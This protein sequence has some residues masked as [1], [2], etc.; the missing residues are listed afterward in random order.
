MERSLRHN[1]YVHD[2]EHPER[3]LVLSPRGSRD[4]HAAFLR[5]A[6]G[7]ADT[8]GKNQLWLYIPSVSSGRVHFEWLRFRAVLKKNIADRLSLVAL[9]S[10]R[11]VSDPLIPPVA[12]AAASDT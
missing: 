1:H 10:D 7:I 8:P 2:S 3:F 4:L 11:L 12:A 9:A 6:L 5:I